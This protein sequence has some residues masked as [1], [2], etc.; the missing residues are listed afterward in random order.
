MGSGDENGAIKAKLCI[1]RD[2]LNREL[3][4]SG[5]QPNLQG[6][7]HSECDIGRRVSRQHVLGGIGR[8]SEGS[9]QGGSE[10]KI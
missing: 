6:T 4:R 7:A 5:L 9:R 1:V 10:K 3:K 2:S 8:Q